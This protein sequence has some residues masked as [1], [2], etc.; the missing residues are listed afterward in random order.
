M[1]PLNA[2]KGQKMFLFG[3]FPI[4]CPYHYHVGPALVIEA[5]GLETIEFKYEPIT[6]KGI[7]E[8]VIEDNEYNIFYRL[9]NV[10][11]LK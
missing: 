8:L 11:I 1:F 10:K 7:L 6:I 3:P 2:D 9:R 5:Y 4:S